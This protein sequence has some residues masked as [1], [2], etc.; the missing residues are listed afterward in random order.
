MAP[1]FSVGICKHPK[2]LG[3]TW[4]RFLSLLCVKF[5]IVGLVVVGKMLLSLLLRL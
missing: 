2:N 1:V 3:F 5:A 4:G